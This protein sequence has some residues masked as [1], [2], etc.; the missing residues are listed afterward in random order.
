M[1]GIT[2]DL[3]CWYTSLVVGSVLIASLQEHVFAQIIPDS[4]LPNNSVI[5]SDGNTSNITGGTQA[6]SNLFHSFREFSVSTDRVASFNN[7]VDIQN[8]ISRV[9]GRSV[10]QIDGIIRTLATANLFLINPNGIIFGR[11]AQLNIG[12]SFVGT[13]ANAIGFGN[14]GFFSAL[15]PEAPSPLLTVNPNV[16]L[17]N[18]IAA[19]PIRNSS[20]APAKVDPAGADT[21]GLRVPNGRSLLLVGGD[22]NMDGGAL[23]APGGRVELGGL[24]SAGTVGLN[25]DD[26]NLNL[27]FP[28]S[29]ERSDVFL[30][31]GAFVSV[32]AG[33]G[34]SIAVN[35]RNFE[36]TGESQLFAGIGRG[37]G[38]NSSKAGNISVNAAITMNLYGRS[39]ITNQV[40]P[41]ANGQGGDVNISASSFRLEDRVQVSTITSGAGKGKAGNLTVNAQ[42]VQIIG[43]TTLANNRDRP[44]SL[45]TLSNSAGDAGN[46][47]IKAGTLLLRDEALVV[48]TTLGEGKGGNLTINAQDVQIT[49]TSAVST[50]AELNS[51]GNAGNLTIKANALLVRDGA[52]VAT[53]ALGVGN[54]GT[55]VIDA[56][57]I[58]LDAVKSG[59]FSTLGSTTAPIIKVIIDDTERPQ[60][61]IEPREQT[62]NPNAQGNS[63]NINITS[64][65]LTINNGA[66]LS[67]STFGRGNAGSINLNTQNAVFSGTDISGLSS[68]LFS[69]VE[70][71][72]VGNA[73]AIKITTNELTL[74]GG[75]Q[76]VASSFGEGDAGT[77]TIEASDKFLVNGA[78]S[79][80]SLTGVFAESRIGRGGNIDL[81][82]ENLF[83]LRNQGLISATSGITGSNGIDGNISIGTKFLVAVPG[84]NSDIIATGFGR[85]PGSN[86]QVNAQGIFGTQ[87][88]QQLSPKS[89]IIATG[90]VTLNTPD[91]DPN[92]GLVNLPSVPIDSEVVQFCHSPGYAQSSFIITGRG[93]LPLDP[94]T[95]F[96][97]TAD[98]VSVGWVS[99]KPSTREGKSPPVT[100]K[101]TTATPKP[102][103]E[104]TGWVMNAKGELE[105]TANAPSTPHGS[106]QNPVSCRAS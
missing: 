31:N 79:N 95:D 52:Q 5:T 10:S 44:I 15:N 51:T 7:A 72:A 6:G 2:Q 66:Q 27:S 18:Q 59:I 46:L 104:A 40:L 56:D 29:V 98:T 19:V 88:Q 13:T 58:A 96:L 67:V 83:M 4:T 97:T 78:N 25:G 28:D 61:T 55:I 1:S 92:S 90:Q 94:T 74:N 63:G 42:N 93:G 21:F 26:N 84:E 11:N 101:P 9:T 76:L 3:R 86:I 48:A 41:E 91:I 14:L 38:S 64:G 57:V 102:I 47:T 35:A 33:D 50:S 71:E 70:K 69:A 45:L 80:G 8:I 37:L 89:D 49:G 32:V 54:A 75:A 30:S 36:M 68:G 100:I 73:G 43:T 22:I 24:R 106:W 53:R 77:V 20:T 87:F 60:V 34:G 82:I 23:F 17:F 65:L 39:R 105:L 81:K 99:L 103:V 16:L 12:G 62:I 85:S